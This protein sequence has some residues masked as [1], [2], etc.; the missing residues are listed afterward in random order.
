MATKCIAVISATD[1]PEFVA[2][3]PGMPSTHALYEHAIDRE[4]ANWAGSG[5]HRAIRVPISVADIGK[6]KALKGSDF[7][8]RDLTA[9]ATLK[10]DGK[11]G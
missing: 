11:L 8:F 1:F 4:A 9:L 6:Y 3:V 5:D 2:Q 10:N 7:T